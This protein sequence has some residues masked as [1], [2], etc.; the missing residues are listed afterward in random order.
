MTYIHALPDAVLGLIEIVETPQMT[1]AST[2]T[3]SPNL[4]FPRAI[5]A[6][7][8]LAKN[9]KDACSGLKGATDGIAKF[10]EG[11]AKADKD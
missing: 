7:K 2:I 9:A 5:K 4:A 1:A 11:M 8:R 6:V 3:P 10:Q